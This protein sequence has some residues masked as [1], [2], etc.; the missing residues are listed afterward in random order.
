MRRTGEAPSP[1][2][3]QNWEGSL[4]SEDLKVFLIKEHTF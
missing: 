2:L 1:T 3:P 4:D